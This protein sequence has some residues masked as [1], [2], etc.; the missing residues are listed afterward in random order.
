MVQGK[1]WWMDA[2]KQ[3]LPLLICIFHAATVIFLCS[4]LLLHL[5]SCFIHA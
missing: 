2:G 4:S 3:L 5:F 1:W